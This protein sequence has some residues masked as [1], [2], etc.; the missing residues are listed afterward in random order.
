MA[1][2]RRGSCFLDAPAGLEASSIHPSSWNGTTAGLLTVAPTVAKRGAVAGVG[3][4]PAGCGQAGL[5]FTPESE[6]RATRRRRPAA[7][8]S[9]FCFVLAG[10]VTRE[11]AGKQTASR[12]WGGSASPVPQ[13]RRSPGA[14]LAGVCC[15]CL[16]DPWGRRWTIGARRCRPPP[17]PC[18]LSPGRTNAWVNPPPAESGH[19]LALEGG[20]VVEDGRCRP[21][22]GGVYSRARCSLLAG[23]TPRSGWCWP[24]PG[25]E[26]PR[27]KER[28]PI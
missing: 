3:P 13:G 24:P 1:C 4:L 21:P 12:R 15:P 10:G 14:D 2:S 23:R 25:V 27:R 22:H 5:R 7:I 20:F 16:R 18:V 9:A 11:P 19:H 26:R 28:F 17:S 6:S 8:C